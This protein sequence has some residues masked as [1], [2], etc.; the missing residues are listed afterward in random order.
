[1]RLAQSLATGERNKNASLDRQV[2]GEVGAR[3]GQAAGAYFGGVGAPIG[4]R[5]GRV[6]GENWRII[7]F[8]VFLQVA[9]PILLIIASLLLVT[10]VVSSIFS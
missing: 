5:I 2:A 3:V 9:M 1:V 10:S 7:A 4:K 8:I 6:A